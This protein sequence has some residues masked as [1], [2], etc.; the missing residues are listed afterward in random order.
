MSFQIILDT[1]LQTEDK[2]EMFAQYLG[3]LLDREGIGP[4][5]VSIRES[6]GHERE[7]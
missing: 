4:T 6:G 1:N 7:V 3:G 5:G 2:A